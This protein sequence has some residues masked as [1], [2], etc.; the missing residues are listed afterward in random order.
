[1]P[2]ITIPGS[3]YRFFFYSGEGNEPAHVHVSRSGNEAKFWLCPVVL[4]NN[5]GFAV[6]ELNK[7]KQLV[8]DH[9]NEIQQAWNKHFSE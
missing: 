3:P 6:H 7:I 5:D 8:K 1:M 9:E 2:A 4:A